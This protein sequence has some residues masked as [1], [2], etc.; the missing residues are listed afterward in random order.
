MTR[1]RQLLY[2]LILLKIESTTI[3]AQHNIL[4][5]GKG[6]IMCQFTLDENYC[7]ETVNLQLRLCYYILT[8]K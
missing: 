7:I 3:T 2:F 5:S 4:K 8:S 1:G 6:A